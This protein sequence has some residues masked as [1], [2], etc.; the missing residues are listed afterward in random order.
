MNNTTLTFNSSNGIE[1]AIRE[2]LEGKEISFA[3]MCN[4]AGEPS[5]SELPVVKTGEILRK[6]YVRRGYNSDN[7]DQEQE[8]VVEGDEGELRFKTAMKNGYDPEKKTPFFIFDYENSQVKIIH[9]SQDGHTV[10]F[11][12]LAAG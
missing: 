7:P 3:T 10:K 1:N 8:L 4:P 6:V 9:R 5:A 2:I 11:Y 12:I